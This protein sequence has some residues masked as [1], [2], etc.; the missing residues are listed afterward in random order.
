VSTS[1]GDTAWIAGAGCSAGQ[2]Q[3]LATAKLPPGIARP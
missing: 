3:P 1:K 2:T